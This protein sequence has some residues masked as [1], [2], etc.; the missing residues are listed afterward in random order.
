MHFNPDYGSI[1]LPLRY[2][3]MSV[4]DLPEPEE[5]VTIDTSQLEAVRHVVGELGATHFVVGRLPVDGTFPWE[6]TVGMEEFLTRMITDPEFVQRA[7][8]AYVNRS[9]A[10]I[11]AMLETGVDAVMTGDDYSDN[12][13][14]IMGKELFRK[15]ILPGIKRQCEATHALGGIFIKH[16][17]GKVWE[18]LEDLV[19][20]GVDAWHGIQPSIGMDLRLLKL[21]YGDKLCFFGGVDCDTLIAADAEGVRQEVRY[22]LRN[23]A[24][25]G[26]LVVT[27]SN[28]L[29]PG[30][31]LEN[32]LAMRDE[33]RKH[34]AYPICLP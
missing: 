18:L 2:P 28:V 32:Y 10:W 9:L 16:T 4:E 22:A 13:G 30:M 24:P 19:D 11:A 14:P 21:R 23:A 12:R 25:G 7:V 31:K 17:D 6:H 33:L 29:Q 1:I 34:G 26:D 27:S 8:E 15:F 5:P 3:E 20:A